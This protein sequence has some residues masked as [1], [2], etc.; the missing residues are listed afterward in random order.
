MLNLLDFS[1]LK[2]STMTGDM[3]SQISNAR[4]QFIQGFP[5]A[6]GREFQSRRFQPRSNSQIHP[7]RI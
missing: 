6:G 5:K 1:A 3:L 7:C 4:A 2:L